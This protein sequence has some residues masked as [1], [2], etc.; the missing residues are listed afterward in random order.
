MTDIDQIR[1]VVESKIIPILAMH[2]G[3]LELLDFD[4]GVL[5][6]RLTGGCTGCPSSQI[7]I[8]HNMLMQQTRT[9][10]IV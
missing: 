10:E 2:N 5:L 8:L 3:G 7:T 6:I 4:D 9:M 1:K